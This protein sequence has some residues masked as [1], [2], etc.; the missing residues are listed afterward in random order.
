MVASH[1]ATTASRPPPPAGPAVNLSRRMQ[2]GHRPIVTGHPLTSDLQSQVYIAVPIAHCE[3]ERS[4]SPAGEMHRQKSILSFLQK[5]SAETNSSCDP[6]C[7]S[8]KKS[9][10]IPASQPQVQVST[11]VGNPTKDPFADEVRGTDTPPEKIPRPSF[12]SKCPATVNESIVNPFSSILHKF[13]RDDTPKS[14]HRRYYSV[15]V[16]EYKNSK[17]LPSPKA[18]EDNIEQKLLTA[19]MKAPISSRLHSFPLHEGSSRIDN[20]YSHER[21]ELAIDD[22]IN[23]NDFVYSIDEKAQNVEFDL[24]L[25]GPETPTMC[26]QASNIKRIWNLNDFDAVACSGLSGSSKRQKAN[27]PFLEKG[28]QDEKLETCNKFEWLNPSIIRDANGRRPSDPLYDQRTLYIPPDALKKMSASQKQYWSKGR[29][30]KQ[31]H[32]VRGSYHRQGERAEQRPD[33]SDREIFLT[34]QV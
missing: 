20:N 18:N 34:Q 1:S 15:G 8:G 17:P 29:G 30:G 4:L 16:T 24:D 6:L 32:A 7:F 5:P 19:K 11:L 10:R 23:D 26:R 22:R 12:T 27:E 33:R 14:F 31:P 13:T 3:C 2:V 9:D 25:P 21:D 28:V